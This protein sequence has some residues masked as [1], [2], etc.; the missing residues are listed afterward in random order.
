[1][2]RSVGYRLRVLRAIWRFQWRPLL[3]WRLRGG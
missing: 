3:L 2:I 1:M